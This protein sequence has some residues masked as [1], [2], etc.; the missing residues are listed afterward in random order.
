[1][2]TCLCNNICWEFQRGSKRLYRKGSHLYPQFPKISS[3]FPWISKEAA[4]KK[5]IHGNRKIKEIR[6]NFR[7]YHVIT[8]NFHFPFFLMYA[9]FEIC[10]AS[11]ASVLSEATSELCSRN[12]YLFYNFFK[13]YLGSTNTT[14]PMSFNWPER[15]FN[16]ASN[17]RIEANGTKC[18]WFISLK[19]SFVLLSNRWVI[20]STSLKKRE[21]RSKSIWAMRKT[22]IKVP[23]KLW[24]SRNSRARL[25]T[26]IEPWKWPDNW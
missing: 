7:K 11:N 23:K 20:K 10:K 21:P 17:S 22:I 9:C 8:Y 1:M 15:I 26:N 6:E 14:H 25:V 18:G 19:P 3:N 5:E 13:W 12:T 4:Q 24:P 2:N 16:L